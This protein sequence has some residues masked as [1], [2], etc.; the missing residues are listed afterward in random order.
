MYYLNS[1]KYLK[2]FTYNH[3]SVRKNISFL[4]NDNKY[5]YLKEL[6]L[7]EENTGVYDGKWDA[8]G[9]V[10]IS[11]VFKNY[12]KLCKLFIRL[13]RHFV[14]QMVNQ[15]LQYV[16]VMKKIITDVCLMLLMHGN[17]GLIYLHQNEEKL[18]GKLAV[19]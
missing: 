15:L 19:H 2:N 14:Q 17:I 6:G 12:L 1:L 10:S 9:N 13:L 8:N 16:M 3:F 11:Y 18:L 7:N 4:I 5:S